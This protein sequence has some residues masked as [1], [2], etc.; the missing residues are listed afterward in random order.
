M[1]MH[2]N[3]RMEQEQNIALKR[4][5]KI[6]EDL[7]NEDSHVL[8]S[9]TS[10]LTEDNNNQ[11]VGLDSADHQTMEFLINKEEGNSNEIIEE[12]VESEEINESMA[13]D[14]LPTPPRRKKPS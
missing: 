2:N 7:E 5:T 10:S 9:L 14:K 11:A 6:E 3:K 12:R 1:N 4:L 13:F 8:S